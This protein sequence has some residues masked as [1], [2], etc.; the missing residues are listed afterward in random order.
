MGNALKFENEVV[1]LWLDQSITQKQIKQNCSII[2]K[3]LK[4]LL[5]QQG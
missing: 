1:N 5:N 4:E 2:N 3:T